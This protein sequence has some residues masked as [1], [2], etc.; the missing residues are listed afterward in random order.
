[1][2]ISPVILLSAVAAIACATHGPKPEGNRGS[3]YA[4]DRFANRDLSRGVVPGAAKSTGSETQEQASQEHTSS[5]LLKRTA[6]LPLLGGLGKA[7]KTGPGA[8]AAPGTGPGTA[9]GPGPGG[10]SPFGLVKRD[11]DLMDSVTS[12]IPKTDGSKA[13]GSDPINSQSL[14]K[15]G[16]SRHQGL[17]DL[18]SIIKLKIDV[19]VKAYIDILLHALVDVKADI[20]AK[21]CL[22]LGIDLDAD[23]VVKI[24]AIVYARIDAILKLYLNTDIG[25]MIGHACHRHCRHSCG[26]DVDID[27]LTDIDALLKIDL[28]HI[29]VDLDINILADIRLRLDALGIKIKTDID[30]DL[31]LDL[32]DLLGGILGSCKDHHDGILAQLLHLLE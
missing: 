21:I 4:R 15:R 17:L 26:S 14:V 7:A 31:D 8:V 28:R 6:G 23:I 3:L 29:L 24:R 16:G 19:V 25:V 13:S 18:D 1:M 32:D 9:A 22:K 11:N 10:I 20:L 2:R 5:T 30:L 12:M 27:I